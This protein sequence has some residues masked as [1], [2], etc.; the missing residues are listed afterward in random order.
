MMKNETSNFQIG[1]F[2]IEQRSFIALIILIAIVSVINPDFFSVDNI[3]NIYVKLQLMRL[4]Q[5]G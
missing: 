3:L 1:R 4:L 5:L 2:L